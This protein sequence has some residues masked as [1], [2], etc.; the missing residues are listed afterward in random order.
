MN[1]TP[2]SE[3]YEIPEE[4]LPLA[5]EKD[6]LMSLSLF[7][8]NRYI[9]KTGAIAERY[10]LECIKQHLIN[11]AITPHTEPIASTYNPETNSIEAKPGYSFNSNKCLFEK[12][13]K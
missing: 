7:E 13:L 5:T 1:N 8:Y 6:V 10:R 9:N 4:Y 2:D 3:G 11:G 12:V